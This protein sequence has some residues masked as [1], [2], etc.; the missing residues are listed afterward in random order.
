VWVA[1][2]TAAQNWTGVDGWVVGWVG[3]EA[4][5]WRLVQRHVAN[6]SACGA[7]GWLCAAGAAA[8]GGMLPQLVLLGRWREEA[9][10]HQLQIAPPLHTL[11]RPS[12]ALELPPLD[13]SCPHVTFVCG[14]ALVSRA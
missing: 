3:G 6:P 8:V 14:T 9:D 7:A 4:G 5:D 10:H 11:P 13:R 1:S 2:S 12:Q